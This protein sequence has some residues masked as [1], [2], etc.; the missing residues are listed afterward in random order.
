M[1]YAM[2]RQGKSG[3]VIGKVETRAKWRCYR[4]IRQGQSGDVIGK[5]E[6]RAKWRCYRQSG[7]KGK[8]EM[9]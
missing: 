4:K 2:W 1:L 9:L 5:V 8:V 6:T 3:D 7:G